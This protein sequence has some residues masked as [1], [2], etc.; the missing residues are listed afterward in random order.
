MANIYS[1]KDGGDYHFDDPNAWEGGIVPGPSDVAYVRHNFTQINSGSG[2]YHW[3]GV[4]PSIRVDNTQYLPDSGSFYTYS[5]PEGNQIKIDYQ[6]KDVYFLYSCSIDHS[7]YNWQPGESGPN[8]GIIRNDAKVHD[9]STRVYLSG[10]AVWEV[11]RVVVEDQAEFVMKDQ[12][13]LRLNSTSGDSYVYVADGIFKALDEVTCEITGSTRR[14]SGFIVSGGSRHSQILVSGSSDPRAKTITTSQISAGSATIPVE[15][16]TQFGEGDLI[17]L[18]TLEDSEPQISFIDN[19]TYDPYLY[20]ETGS[21]F[22]LLYRKKIKDEDET[23]QVVGSGNGELYV[24]KMF[25]K[26]GE[27]ISSTNTETRASYQRNFT[28]TKTS[29][30]VRSGHNDFNAGEKIVVDGDVYLILESAKKLVPHKTVDFS[31]GAGLEDFFVDEMIGSGSDDSYKVNSHMRSG[32]FLTLDKEQIGT[33]SFYKSFYLKDTKLRDAK[34]TLSGSMIDESGS[35]DGNR[36]VGVSFGDEAYQRDRRLSFYDRYS[37]ANESYIGVYG[38]TLRFGRL[39][40]DANYA[41]T[42]NFE[43]YNGVNTTESSF[44]VTIDRFKENADY[45]FN[46]DFLQNFQ[47]TYLDSDIGIHL[48]REGALVHSLVVEEYVQEL[49]LDTSDAISVGSKIHEGGTLVDHPAN[50]SIIKIASKIKDLRG[51]TDLF[52]QRSLGNI[53]GSFVPLFWSNN[54]NHIYYRNSDTTS[55][56]SR[57][58]GMLKASPWNAYFRVLS[59]GDR[60][61]DLNLTEGVTFDAIGITHTYASNGAYLKGFGVEVSN[62]GHTWTVLKAQAD[63][64]RVGGGAS[65]HRVYRLAETTARFLRIRVNGGSSSANNYINKLSLYHF[66]SRGTSIELSNAADYPVGARIVFIDPQGFSNYGYNYQRTGGSVAN[67]Y[68]AGTLDE[69]DI[70]GG[71]YPYYTITAKSGNIVTLDREVEGEYL[72]PDTFVVRVD[73]SIKVTSG[74]RYPLGLFYGSTGSSERKVEFYNVQADSLGNNTRERNYWYSSPWVGKFN[75]MNCSFNYLYYS[76]SPFYAAGLNWKNNLLINSTSQNLGNTQRQSDCSIHGNIVSAYYINLYSTS[77]MGTYTTGN[78]FVGDRRTSLNLTY[79]NDGTLAK[80]VFRNNY[81][82]ARDYFHN[83]LGSNYDGNSNK[84]LEFYG[85]IINQNHSQFRWYPQTQE[86]ATVGNKFEWPSMYPAVKTNTFY[87]SGQSGFNKRRSLGGHSGDYITVF[88]DPELSG[89]S[90]LIDNQ[91]NIIAK[92]L[93]SNEFDVISNHLIRTNGIVMRSDFLVH[94]QQTVRVILNLDYYND[95]FV[96]ENDWNRILTIP[97]VILV[98]PDKRTITLK[99]LPYQDEYGKVTFDHTFTAQ[100]GQYSL[101]LTK[102]EGYG[103]RWM[104]FRESTCIIKGSDEDNIKVLKNGFHDH[105]VLLDSSK[106]NLTELHQE[107]TTVFKNNPNRTTVKFRKIKF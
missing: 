21:V 67:S 23:V 69:S 60:Y 36:M 46:G 48:R 95:M 41:D 12:A 106:M 55:E 11:M 57:T 88:N 83:S 53:S 94:S 40:T 13:T 42:R 6:S 79:N 27:V 105:L 99:E 93:D 71:M 104:T 62:D 56:Y 82:C 80:S 29:V 18:H 78:V 68:I 3:T 50:Q 59:S 30:V 61:F 58:D 31:Q 19:N 35:Y 77:T 76:D 47:A 5:E 4:A 15:D 39:S 96:R 25:G 49:L 90:H 85:N 102:Y 64:T 86:N 32:S 65:N 84:M 97:R 70:V 16:S 28:G 103:S 63:D 20:R 66:D 89:R 54:G 74:G 91:M 34:I 8:I 22:P 1:V 9:K 92:R 100:E 75:I 101:V 98:G 43:E 38:P 45:Y 81:I 14:N 107:G 51:Y 52:A 17:S 10:S 7:H 44:E 37:Y 72:T 87:R 24:R 2:I 26:E 73:R 33:N